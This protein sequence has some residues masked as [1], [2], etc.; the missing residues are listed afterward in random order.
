MCIGYI[1]TPVYMCVCIYM[2]ISMKKLVQIGEADPRQ[3]Y[4]FGI[5]IKKKC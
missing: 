4:S 5:P 3:P 2:Y 1:Y